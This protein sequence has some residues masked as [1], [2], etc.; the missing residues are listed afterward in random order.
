MK[1]KFETHIGKNKLVIE[2]EKMSDLHKWGSTYMGI[3]KK[4]D[5]CG[6]DDLFLS[7]KTPSGFEYFL[8]ECMDCHAS[9]NFGQKADRSGLYWKGDKMEVYQKG[10]GNPPDEPPTDPTAG[11][12]QPEPPPAGDTPNW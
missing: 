12:A 3:P 7:Y 1:I 2:T 11:Y 6:S 4:C 9:A 8:V 10:A 5:A